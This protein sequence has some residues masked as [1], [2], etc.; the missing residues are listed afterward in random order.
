MRSVLC[1]IAMREGGN[2]INRVQLELIGRPSGPHRWQASSHR[3][4]GTSAESGRMAGGLR[5]QASSYR[6]LGIS[7]ESGRLAGRLRWQASSYKGLGI[8]AESGRLAGRLRWQA[9]S[10]KGF[11]YICK[12]SAAGKLQCRSVKAIVGASLLAMDSKRHV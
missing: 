6:G 12:I 2:V 9:S 4:L 7:A 8:S 5:W 1:G 10:Y 3:V 11:V